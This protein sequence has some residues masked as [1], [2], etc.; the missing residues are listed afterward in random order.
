MAASLRLREA[1]SPLQTLADPNPCGSPR[2]VLEVLNSSFIDPSPFLLLQG[3]KDRINKWSELGL[4]L[5]LAL[6]AFIL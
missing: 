4:V 2:G 3:E 5:L 1:H 6:V